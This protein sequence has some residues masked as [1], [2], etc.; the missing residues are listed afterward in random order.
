MCQSH[1]QGRG[2]QPHL[3]SR[4]II[5]MIEIFEKKEENAME[6]T[7]GVDFE[8]FGLSEATLRAIRNKGYTVS[9]PVQAGAFRP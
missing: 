8:S 7:Q 6:I 2:A 3:D 1:R 9:T 5:R 4:D